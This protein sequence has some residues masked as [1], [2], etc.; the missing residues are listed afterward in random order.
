MPVYKIT[1][2]IEIHDNLIVEIEAKNVHEAFKIATRDDLD[3]SEVTL[4]DIGL[5]DALVIKVENEEG[6]RF[7]ECTP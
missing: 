7:Y 4:G 3:L 6:Q 5:H 2:D 1:Y